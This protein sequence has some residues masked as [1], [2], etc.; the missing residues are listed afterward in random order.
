MEKLPGMLKKLGDTDY[1]SNTIVQ[2]GVR[3]EV[4][5]RVE[6]TSE[7]K[8]EEASGM[9]VITHTGAYGQK[10][11]LFQGSE[12]RCW[13]CSKTDSVATF[14]EKGKVERCIYIK[15]LLFDRNDWDEMHLQFIKANSADRNIYWLPVNPPLLCQEQ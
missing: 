8:V 10:K 9:A 4:R 5:T 12:W 6:I 2:D 13:N 3:Y 7:I 1:W 15:R 11:F 14:E